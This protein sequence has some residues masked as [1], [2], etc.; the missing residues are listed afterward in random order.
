MTTLNRLVFL[1]MYKMIW[2]HEPRSRAV[3]SRYLACFVLSLILTA[4]ACGTNNKSTRL[5]LILASVAV[6]LLMY[7]FSVYHVPN[8]HHIGVVV[9]HHLERTELWVILILGESIIAMAT[10]TSFVRDVNFY[11]TA[12]CSFF[13]VHSMMQLFVHSQPLHHS[14]FDTHAYELTQVRALWFN[15]CQLLITLGLFGMAVGL[16]FIFAYG[17]GSDRG[18]WKQEYGL[19]FSVSCGW[20]VFWLQ[21]SRYCHE[22]ANRG[23]SPAKRHLIWGCNA[24]VAL[25]MAAC[26]LLVSS[27]PSRRQRSIIDDSANI[28]HVSPWNSILSHGPGWL[29]Q[30]CRELLDSGS[31]NAELVERYRRGGSQSAGHSGYVMTGL[32]SSEF[33]GCISALIVLLYIAELNLLPTDE[34]KLDFADYKGNIAEAL[35]G[36]DDVQARVVDDEILIADDER[37]SEAALA[38]IF[39]NT[40]DLNESMLSSAVSVNHRRK[41]SIARNENL[42]SSKSTEKPNDRRR[43]SVARQL[44]VTNGGYM[45]AGRPSHYRESK[46]MS[47]PI[48][49]S[50]VSA[51]SAS[52]AT[53]SPGDLLSKISAIFKSDTAPQSELGENT[54]WGAAVR[55][56]RTRRVGPE[57]SSG[58]D[59]ASFDTTLPIKSKIREQEH[60]SEIL[61]LNEETEPIEH[62]CNHYTKSKLLA[63]SEV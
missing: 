11:G 39:A 23:Y 26:G 54:K 28:A 12:C 52:T 57:I 14:G 53:I 27:E 21:V 42:V 4:S 31:L 41:S 55:K 51:S 45:G 5:N 43:S 20:A 25:G 24:L 44:C 17:V 9:G 60:E 2:T 32:S 7:P 58:C 22:W 37:E 63:V 50:R 1:V 33:L 30:Y 48:R 62:N 29:A 13:V 34:A 8:T 36:K 46:I 40:S 10:V 19:L 49:F 15:F 38:E 35:W 18:A 47:N 6:E 61:S 16:K 56:L 59:S 3:V